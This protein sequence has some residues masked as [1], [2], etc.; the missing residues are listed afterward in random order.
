MKGSLMKSFNG[1]QVTFSEEE[2]LIIELMFRLFENK[3]Q[4][5]LDLTQSSVDTLEDYE[6]LK[7]RVIF[8]LEGGNTH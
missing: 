6:N 1:R 3:I 4:T 5:S 7:Q 2:L 8:A